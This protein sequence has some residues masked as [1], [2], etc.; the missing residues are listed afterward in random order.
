ML[1]I[2]KHIYI[3]NVLLKHK[4]NLFISFLKDLVIRISLETNFKF[5]SIRLSIVWPKF[6]FLRLC[7][8]IS[9]SHIFFFF[10]QFLF[11]S[12]PKSYHIYHSQ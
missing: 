1:L 3:D 9:H 2:D 6:I 12:V 5:P 7:Q 4:L 8:I 10:S 11:Y